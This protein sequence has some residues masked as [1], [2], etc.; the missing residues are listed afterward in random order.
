VGEDVKRA[1]IEFLP[2]LLDDLVEKMNEE[3]LEDD[4]IEALNNALKAAKILSSDSP[5]IK[6]LL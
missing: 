2:D 3:T 1:C 4:E 5:E 6:N